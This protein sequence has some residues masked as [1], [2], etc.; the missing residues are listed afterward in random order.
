VFAIAV[1]LTIV[2]GLQ[3]VRRGYIDWQRVEV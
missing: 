3:I 1:A 2:S